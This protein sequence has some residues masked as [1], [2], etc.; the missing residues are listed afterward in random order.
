MF[1][2]VTSKESKYKKNKKTEQG[3]TQPITS[4]VQQT[5]TT[6]GAHSRRNLFVRKCADW[7]HGRLHY[8]HIHTHTHTHTS[9]ICIQYQ[10]LLAAY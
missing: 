5:M 7:S 1:V 2:D 8:T 6:K 10:V 4:L 9:T 3:E